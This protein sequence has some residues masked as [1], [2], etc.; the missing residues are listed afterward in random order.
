MCFSL[1]GYSINSRG[2]VCGMC[3]I[4]NTCLLRYECTLLRVSKCACS[5]YLCDSTV[6]F[7]GRTFLGME[8]VTG[9]AQLLNVVR[10]VDRTLTDFHLDT[11]YQVK[12][13]AQFSYA[14][15]DMTED[16]HVLLYLVGS[17]IPSEL[18]LVCWGL[19]CAIDTTP[20]WASGAVR[21]AM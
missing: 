9:H 21:Y 10:V 15:D 1:L 19:H 3:V 13:D 7:F 2:S 5:A 16:T 12:W 14:Q 4:L 20:S 18:G 17:V 11:F 6:I 8:V